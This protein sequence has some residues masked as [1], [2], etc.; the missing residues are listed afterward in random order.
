LLQRFDRWLAARG[1]A[2]ATRR[3]YGRAV[4]AWLDAGGTAGHVVPAALHAFLAARLA[5]R[6]RPSVAVDCAALAAFY[7]CQRDHDD[8]GEAA[9]RAIPRLRSAERRIVM[10]YTADQVAAAIAG[11]GDSW[12][13]QRDAALLSVLAETGLTS[14]EAARLTLADVL[15]EGFLYIAA[16]GRRSARYV[17]ISAALQITLAKWVRRRAEAAPG[18]RQALWITARGTGMTSRTRIGRIVATRLRAALGGA[19]GIVGR[20]PAGRG[21]HATRLRITAG[22]AMLA[23]GLSITAVAQI[24]GLTDVRQAVHYGEQD[25]TA[26]RRALARLPRHHGAASGVGP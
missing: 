9:V 2:L 6:Q 22:A 19:A 13:G 24:L 17:P 16:A 25:L 10:A 21:H 5:T 1:R 18:K 14:A 15:G 11:C 23:R 26:L 4:R 20:A 12:R 7:A 3:A 8:A